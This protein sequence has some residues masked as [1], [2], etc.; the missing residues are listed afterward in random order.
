MYAG[1]AGAAAGQFAAPHG[2][3][4]DRAVAVY[5]ADT[6]N[7]RI[8]KFS[9]SGNLLGMIDGSAAGEGKFAAPTGVTVTSTGSIV[10]AAGA[11]LVAL[12]AVGRFD[13]ELTAPEIASPGWIDVAVDGDDTV[14]ALD[15]ASGRVA[16]FRPD[17]SGATFGGTGSGDGQLLNPTGLAV[18]SGTIAVADAG[19][20]RIAVFDAA[21]AFLEAISVA[22][23]VGAEV[24]EADVAIDESGTIWA[25]SPATNAVL[26]YR[27]DG[28]FARTISSP[29][30]ELL[31]RPSGLALRPGG[32]LFVANAGGNR[33]SLLGFI[34]P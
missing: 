16:V 12:D 21:G 22:E 1:G 24:P 11:R 5:V 17:G 25:S 4:Y 32:W 7:D 10:V 28:T 9:S 29:G 6:G 18:R 2:L 33:I 15:A 26:I 3:A 30:A 34:N 23:W 20:A 19:N 31:D 8:Q 13:H 27:P 14:F